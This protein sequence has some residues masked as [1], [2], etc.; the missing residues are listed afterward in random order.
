MFHFKAYYQ[1]LPEQEGKHYLLFVSW[2]FMLAGYTMKLHSLHLL[3]IEE[4]GYF[5]LTIWF[6]A[7]VAVWVLTLGSVAAP[8]QLVE[9]EGGWPVLLS[10]A[11][12]A[13]VENE[14][15]VGVPAEDVFSNL[16]E[17]DILNDHDDRC[18]PSN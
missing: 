9:P 6:I 16:R 12:R 7:Y 2:L 1:G 11:S 4:G 10:P 15:G 13:R 5:Y 8:I 14:Q 3:Y 17:S 18:H